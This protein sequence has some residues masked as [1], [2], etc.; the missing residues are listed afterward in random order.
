[1]EAST[2]LFFL[3]TEQEIKMDVTKICVMIHEWL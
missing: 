1:L 3:Q 2:F